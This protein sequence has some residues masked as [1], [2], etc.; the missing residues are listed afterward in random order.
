MRLTRRW[1]SLA[2]VAT[3]AATLVPGGATAAPAEAPTDEAAFAQA[4]VAANAGEYGVAASDLADLKVVS[5]YT[6]SHNRVTHV[7]LTPALPGPRGLRRPRH[8]ATCRDG[9]VLFVGESF[10]ARAER[11][12]IRARPSST[13]RKRSRPRPTSSTS[14]T[15]PAFASSPAP[16]AWVA[17]R[18]CSG[19]GISSSPIPARLGWQPTTNGLRLAWQLAID[20]TSEPKTSGTRPSTPRPAPSWASRTGRSQDRME[21]L[22][23]RLGRPA[24]PSIV[25]RRSDVPAAAR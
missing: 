21:D 6:S 22:D 2:M 3:L 15:R 24:A 8:R 19:G 23:A 17:R 7:N 16:R 11:R 18:P 25:R 5:S 4:F 10:V 1:V 20:A 13:R 9:K 14:T 12:R